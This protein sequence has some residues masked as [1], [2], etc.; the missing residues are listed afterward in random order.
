[1]GNLDGRVAIVTGAG[2]GLG[3]SHAVA[4]AR[5]GAKVIVNDLGT[6]R[7]GIGSDADQAQVVVEEITGFG[8][9]A[10]AN[11]A[12][13]TDWGAMKSLIRLALDVYGGLDVVVNNAG[14]LRDRLVYNMSEEA[15][16]AVIG[17]HV[18]GTFAT[19]HFA[20]EYWRSESKSGRDVNAVV[21][22]TGSH[23]GMHC[24]GGQ[25]AYGTAKAAILAFTLICA[26]DLQRYGVRVNA[27]CPTA[28]TRL[29]AD[30][31]FAQQFSATENFDAL[32]PGHVS[33]LVAYL[34]DADCPFTGEVFGAGGGVYSLYQGWTEICQT[35]YDRRWSAEELAAA[36]SPWSRTVHAVDTAHG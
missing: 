16:D 11:T 13:V 9:E 3:R 1:M 6:T 25:S 29:T 33:T 12:D 24:E 34:A 21:I 36:I 30:T 2:Q 5:A 22:N 35:K 27:I 14:M 20:S 7:E 18:K 28:R 15:W 19:T 26:K 31:Q 4:L 8:G 23:S 17:V 10:V 32:D